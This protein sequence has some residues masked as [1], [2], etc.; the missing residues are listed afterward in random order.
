MNYSWEIFLQ[1][2]TNTFLHD[3]SPE[4]IMDLENKWQYLHNTG[5]YLTRIK[6]G[7]NVGRKNVHD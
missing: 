7:I 2:F 4:I 3:K 6:V 5:T 1:Y